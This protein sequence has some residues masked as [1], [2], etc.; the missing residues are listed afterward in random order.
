MVKLPQ[1]LTFAQLMTKWS[2]LINP[3]ITNPT[4]QA[5]ILHNIELVSGSNT[6]NHKLGRKLQGWR[7]SRRRQFIVATVPTAYDIYDIQDSNQIPTLTLTLT[8]S[9]GT[10]ANPVI[11]DLEVF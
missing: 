2:A 7:I 6:I 11:I 8:C 9:Q 1:Q 5:N 3:I 10:Q 4:N